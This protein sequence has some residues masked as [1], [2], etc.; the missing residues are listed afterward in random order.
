MKDEFLG[1][2]VIGS[3]ISF[4]II[5]W[6][7]FLEFTSFTNLQILL[8][9]AI[10]LTI[11]YVSIKYYSFISKIISFKN[12]NIDNFLN[13]FTK[14]LKI[15]I[16]SDHNVK[17]NKVNKTLDEQITNAVNRLISV[18]NQSPPILKRDIYETTKKFEDRVKLTS[19]EYKKKIESQIK[20]RN[21]YL[22]I[23]NK[24]KKDGNKKTL[25][26]FIFRKNNDIYKTIFETYTKAIKEYYFNPYLS[27][28][29]YNADTKEIRATLKFVS[30]DDYAQYLLFTNIT[31]VQAKRIIEDKNY[32]VVVIFETNFNEV[33][34]A[35]IFLL[36]NEKKFQGEVTDIHTYHLKPLEIKIDKIE[37]IIKPI[38]IEIQQK[39]LNQPNFIDEHESD[40]DN[41]LKELEKIFESKY[42]VQNKLIKS[43]DDK[44][45]RLNA[46]TKDMQIEEL[47]LQSQSFQNTLT[48][49]SNEIQELQNK[50]I[51]K[52]Q[53]TKNLVD[54]L[55]LKIESHENK[56]DVQNKFIKSINS[57]I[58]HLK[59]EVKNSVENNQIEELKLQAKVFQSTLTH[60]SD[61]IIE[62]QNQLIIKEQKTKKLVDSFMS[63]INK[64]EEKIAKQKVVKTQIP[65]NIPTEKQSI[66]KDDGVIVKRDSFD[67]F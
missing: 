45:E 30:L 12:M 27:N 67:D 28:I 63:K 65:L 25:I 64:L 31:P 10:I 8:L 46:G 16:R 4:V 52:E 57:E 6:V 19:L 49:Q 41:K 59:T 26:E 1:N 13:Y 29:I 7:I 20:R 17:T 40:Y 35:D 51:T 62:L 50:L 9:T 61:K 60:Q 54:S 66:K 34:N 53:D 38:K 11:M 55:V 58:E 43:V 15:I 48:S 2:I 3:V 5:L 36:N 23:L 24:I 44:I 42:E 21:K 18:D 37:S 56:Y 33:Y 39:V 32:I 47:K 22:E 14:N